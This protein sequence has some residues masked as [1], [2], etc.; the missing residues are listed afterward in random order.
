M[1]L[2]RRNIEVVKCRSLCLQTFNEITH[3]L[4]RFYHNETVINSSLQLHIYDAITTSFLLVLSYLFFFPFDLAT[5]NQISKNLFIND[6]HTSC[7]DL[8]TRTTQDHPL[9]LG[10]ST[11]ISILLV[12]R[13][14]S[15]DCI[16]SWLASWIIIK[17]SSSVQSLGCRYSAL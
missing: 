6:L 4:W 11:S 13:T 15:C 2:S 8:P 14:N 17:S 1:S 16:R 10:Q 3:K 7:F 12:R 9:S 5:R